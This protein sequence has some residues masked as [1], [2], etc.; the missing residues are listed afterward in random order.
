MFLFPTAFPSFRRET[1]VRRETMELPSG[2]S[3]FEVF[4]RFSFWFWK[5]SF[6]RNMAYSSHYKI[7]AVNNIVSFSQFYIS[8]VW[9]ITANLLLINSGI[10]KTI[11]E[12]HCRLDVI[13]AVNRTSR[14]EDLLVLEIVKKWH[15]RCMYFL[16]YKS[17]SISPVKCI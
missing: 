13:K 17:R 9:L 12:G 2:S 11:E 15:V 16:C 7:P 10:N 14:C 1:T 8:V 5:E 4:S 3:D 6:K